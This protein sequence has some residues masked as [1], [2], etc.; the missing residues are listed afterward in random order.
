MHVNIPYSEMSKPSLGPS[1][2]FKNSKL[3][4]QNSLSGNV[5]GTEISE[6]DFRNQQQTFDRL[7]YARNPN[8]FSSGGGG[9]VGDLKNAEKFGGASIAEIKVSG[10]SSELR[11]ETKKL[12]KQRLDGGGGNLDLV[13]GEGAYLG[14]WA[15][16]KDERIHVKDGVGPSKEELELQ[17]K[18]STNKKKEKDEKIEKIRLEESYGNEKSIF[19][20]E[21]RETNFEDARSRRKIFLFSF[22]FSFCRIL[23]ALP[24][25]FSAPLIPGKSMYD[26][27]GR[28]YMH[29]PTDVDSNLHGE[30][31]SEPSFLPKACVHTWTG[32]TK[33][34]SAIR[35]FPKSGHLMLS[36]SMDTKVKVSSVDT[37]SFSNRR[38]SLRFSTDCLCL[39]FLL[40]NLPLLQLWDVYHEGQCLRTFQGHSKAVKDV[41][42]SNDGRRFLSASYDKQ[43]KLW[44][45]E[46]GQCLS[47]FSNGKI[48]YVVKFNPDEDK[49]NSFLVG[50][51][52]KKIIQW[53]IN[54]KEITQEYDQ[55]LGSVNSITFVDENRRFVT[56]SDDKTMRAWDYDIPVVIKYIADPTMHSMPA[57]SLHPNSEYFET[58]F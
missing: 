52:D 51:N 7:G 26:Y 17:E 30:I 14:P 57:V 53:D 29:I 55:H 23:I 33:G 44:D 5:E 41:T 15:G 47:S 2:P 19:H 16:W 18:L 1:N 35:L 9:F 38:R 34:V 49:Q 58:H 36:G 27:Q 56:T 24:S 42:F 12:K 11:K 48:P 40:T 13:E 4:H 43:I 20:G 28:T 8:T 37:S 45:T 21:L 54:T 22:F 46:T 32:H 6:F 39:S 50:L 25:S 10:N 3:S 31:G